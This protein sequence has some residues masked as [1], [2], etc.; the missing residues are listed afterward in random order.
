[1]PLY[2]LVFKVIHDCP[3]GNFSRRFPSLKM[4]FWCN[5][6][7]DVIEVV[8]VSKEERPAVMEE[9][10]KLPGIIEQTFANGKV[11]LIVRRCSCPIESSVGQVLED[12]NILQFSP[13]VH[14]QGWEFYRVITFHHKD[15]DRLFQRFDEKGFEYEI[16]RK[17]PF[18]GLIASSLTLTADALFSNLTKK[19]I[20]ALLTAHSNGYY[21]FPR[22]T[23]VKT[24]AQ[25]KHVPRT[26]FQE[27]LQ[28]AENKI[29][30]SLVPFLQ[31]YAYMPTEKQQRLQLTPFA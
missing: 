30:S 1:M 26:T 23:N 29:V 18:E 22:K 3:F 31:L 13:V 21:R 4:F 8:S 19:Q 15:I 14:D 9:L 10:S 6:E 12:F 2:E 11:H 27:H 25:Q 16:I 5:G 7:H 20:T 24:I 28:K 17:A